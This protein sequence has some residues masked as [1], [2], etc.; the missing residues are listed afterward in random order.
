MTFAATSHFPWALN[1]PKM[2]L[3]VMP[4]LKR[5]F[6]AFEAQGTC[7]LAANVILSPPGS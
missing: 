1:T 6:C 5:I 2:R 7:L 4:Q 3:A